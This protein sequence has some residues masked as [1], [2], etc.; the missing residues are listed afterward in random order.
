MKQIV[1][2]ILFSFALISCNSNFIYGKDV[3]LPKVGW[4][5]D[6]IIAFQTDSLVNLPPIITFGFNI[7]NNT[8]YYY[9]NMHL[10]FEIKIPGKKEPIRDTLDH[11]LMTPDGY[12][13]KGVEGANIKESVAYYK[14]AIQNPPE[15]IYNINIQ[16]GMRDEVLKDVVSIGARIEKLDQ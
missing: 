15:G 4:H 2:A 7:R 3:D 14:F 1:L 12:W 11:N 9:R 8:D 13:A 10:F 6:S 5:K 16:Q